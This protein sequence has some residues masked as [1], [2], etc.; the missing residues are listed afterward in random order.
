VDHAHALL[1]VEG[2]L[3]EDVR[4]S[5]GI[6]ILRVGMGAFATEFFARFLSHAD[7]DHESFFLVLRGF[8][9][10]DGVVSQ[11]E[12]VDSR[13]TFYRFVSLRLTLL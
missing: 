5:E 3:L 2:L 11:V 9:A 12:G 10:H 13:Q 8:F 4:V 6:D 1:Y 7:V